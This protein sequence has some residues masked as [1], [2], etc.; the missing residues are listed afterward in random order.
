MSASFR[1]RLF[2]ALPQIIGKFGTPFHI[3]D[4]PGI[5]DT[6]RF[7]NGMFPSGLVGFK[8]FYAV[9]ALPKPA[10]ME[11]IKNEQCGFDCSSIPELRL[12]RAAGAQPED[13]MFTSNNTSDEE[14]FEALAHGG[15]ILNL[16]GIEYIEKVKALGPFP[17]LICFRL[18]PGSRKTGDQ[19]NSIIGNPLEAKYGVPIEQIIEAYR[20]AQEAGAKRFGLHTMVCSNDLDWVHMVATCKLLLEVAAELKAKLGIKLEFVN[21]GGGLG[22]Q[23]R[24]G[25]SHFHFGSFAVTCCELVQAFG[26]IHGYIPKIYL[27]SGRFVTGPHGVLVNEVINVYRKYKNYVG[28]EIAMPALMRVGMYSTA[29]HHCTLLNSDGTPIKEGSRPLVMVTVAGSICE[30]CDV[31]ARDIGMPAPRV[32]DLIITHDTGAH[33]S[34]MGF[35]YNGRCRPQELLLGSLGTVRRICRAETFDDLNAR[36]LGL[37]GERHVLQLS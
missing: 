32:G 29:Y 5:R 8:E 28:V 11:I 34:A 35:N 37:E 24:P 13:I 33:G 2:P 30:N 17:E 15:C 4:E 27:E 22:I 3:Y 14:F 36:H 21:L 12:A 25:D 26:A 16:D 18:N 19:V 20:L 9:K 10:I 23:Y 31:L 7:M 1:Q 6:L